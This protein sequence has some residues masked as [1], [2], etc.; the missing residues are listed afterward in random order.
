MNNICSTSLER[1]KHYIETLQ[2]VLRGK[3]T[4]KN[5]KNSWLR[6]DK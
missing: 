1:E 3:V 4:C 5:K 2:Q 6:N